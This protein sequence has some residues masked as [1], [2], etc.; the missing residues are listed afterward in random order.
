MSPERHMS[1]TDAL[2]SIT[3]SARISM[4]QMSSFSLETTRDCRGE[5]DENIL[6]PLS[7][8]SGLLNW[9]SDDDFSLVSDWLLGVVVARS[10]PCALFDSQH[11][12]INESVLRY[13][14]V[15]SNFM[16]EFTCVAFASL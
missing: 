7:L 13:R 5:L 12:P 4:Y 14:C 11:G 1:K 8:L 3:K 2:K 9:I 15:E 6:S 10:V 16:A